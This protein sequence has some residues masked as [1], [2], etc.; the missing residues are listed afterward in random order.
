MVKGWGEE[1][2]LL[3]ENFSIDLMRKNIKR[4]KLFD[5]PVPVSGNKKHN[6]LV[7]R[8][9]PDRTVWSNRIACSVGSDS[10]AQDLLK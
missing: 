9:G 7:V 4:I 6:K 10:N 3:T 5:F 1:I 2:L 8:N